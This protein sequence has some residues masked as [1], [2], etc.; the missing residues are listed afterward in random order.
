MSKPMK[1]G[2]IGLGGVA[3][4]HMGGWLASKHTEVVAGCDIN[5]AHFDRWKQE[6]GITRLA[7]DPLDLIK[8]P[9]LDIIDICTPNTTHAELTIA[10][11][12]SGK[13]VLC[14]KPLAPTVEE[15]RAMIE[16]RDRSG[17]LLMTGHH[18]RFSGTARAIRAEIQAGSLG[19]VYHGRAWWLRRASLP[20]KPTFVVRELSA[21]GVGLD[22]GVHM[23]DLALWLM[24]GPQP[25]SVTGVARTVLATQPGAFSVWGGDIP[26]NLDVDE[27]AAAFIRFANGASLL[28]EVSWMLHHKADRDDMQLWL[29]GDRAGAHWPD[30]TIFETGAQN[31][32][33]YDRKLRLLGGEVPPHHLQCMEFAEAIVNGGSSPV[34]AEDAL[35]VQAILQALYE[36]QRTGREVTIAG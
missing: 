25:V 19:N 1:V 21:G 23:L 31:R 20:V 16:A 10:A 4:L 33:H 15:I 30:C 6:Y 13:H 29:Y 17:R 27:F 35:W 9:E 5:P 28:L 36:S 32:Q 12:E 3:N 34:P 8:D 11:L 7:T 22:L 2:V 14:E 24:G 26:A 18:L